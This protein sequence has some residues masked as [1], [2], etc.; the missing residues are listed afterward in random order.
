MVSGCW[1]RARAARYVRHFLLSVIPDLQRAP[2][3]P[4]RITA[5]IIAAV[6]QKPNLK[7]DFKGNEVC[8]LALA[9]CPSAS[10]ASHLRLPV[11]CLP[12]P[13]MSLISSN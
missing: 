7:P 8:Q 2:E 4:F 6:A 11:P 1:A 13:L 9:V 10:P 5:E 12:Q 3:L